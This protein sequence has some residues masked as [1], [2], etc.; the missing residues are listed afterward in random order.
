[1]KGIKSTL[2]AGSLLFSVLL[3]GQTGND[4]I[5]NEKNTV[6]KG[7]YSIGRNHEKLNGVKTIHLTN[8][9]TD[10][11]ASSAGPTVRKGFFSIRNKDRHRY[12]GVSLYK[13]GIEQGAIHTSPPVIAKG[14]YSIGSNSKKLRS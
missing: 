12:G 1:M 5:K 7:Y 9:Q 8:T 3:F 4:N 10:N 14:Y 11:N 13:Q 6:S 2:L